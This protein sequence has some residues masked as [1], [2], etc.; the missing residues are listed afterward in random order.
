MESGRRDRWRDEE[1]DTI[2]SIRKDRWREGERE[3]SDNRRV[4]RKVDLS[5]RQSGEARR[6]PGER[7][8]DSGNRDTHDLH[9]ESKW[10][11]RWGPDDKDTDVARDKWGDYNKKDRVL[12]KGSSHLPKDERDGDHYRPWRLNSSYA[13]GRM[14]PGNQTLTPNKQVPAF[15]H[16]RGRG[17]NPAHV[18]SLGRGKVTSGVS[19]VTH[20]ASNLQSLG[21]AV[22]KGESGH[23]ELYPVNYS[24]TKLIDIYRVTDMVSYARY[25]EGSYV[26]VPSL[27]QE[28]SIEPLAFCEPT[29]EEVVI[30]K[31]IDEG[32]I[33]SS[34]APQISKD[35]GS[36][37]RI[38]TDH[39]QT[40]RNRIGTKD[41]FPV[42]LDESKHGL[43]SAEG[44]LNYSEGLSHE[45]RAFSDQKLNSEGLM[46]DYGIHQKESDISTA[47]EL[48]SPGSSSILH[49]GS[50]RS[51][52][53]VERPRPTSDRREVP[54][55]I[56]KDFNNVWDSSMMASPNTKNGGPKWQVGDDPVIRRQPPLMFDREPE[57]HKISQPSPEDL[58]LYYKDPQGEI[59]GPF[60]GSDIISWFES[61]YFGLELQVRLGG[62]PPSSPFSL[63]GDVMPHL[64]AKARPPPGFSMTKINE[65][66]DI[67]N[68]LNYSGLGGL[69]TFLG[70]ADVTKNDQ[71]YTQGSATE[72]ENRFLES[73]M[74][75][76]MSGGSLEKF[77]LSEAMQSQCG[78]NTFAQQPP[79]VCNSGDERYAL[80]KMLALERQRSLPNPYTLWPGRD[81]AT[82]DMK[83]TPVAHSKLLQCVTDN[84]STLHHSQNIESMHMF[85]GSSDRPLTA[86]NAASWLNF[87]AG[88]LNPL[89]DKLDIHYHQNFPP[90]SAYGIQQERLPPHT[91]PSANLLNPPLDPSKMLTQENL[92]GSGMSDDPRLLSLL[93]Q[94]YLLQL[95]QQSHTSV[96]S[97]HL[98]IL[99]QM[100]LLK[101]QQKQ[102]EQQ[103]LM[104]QQQQLLSQVL[105]ERE[106][107]QRL[108]EAPFAQLQAGGFM[109]GNA[110]A[111]HI[112]IQQPQELFQIAS[113]SLASNVSVNTPD[114]AL[115]SGV[116]QDISLRIGSDTSMHLPQQNF[117]NN[118]KENN[119][120]ASLLGHVEQ[121]KG[122]SSMDVTDL[123]Q[124][125]EKKIE[126]TSEPIPNINDSARVLNSDIEHLAESISQQ[127]I[128]FSH[129]EEG[130]HRGG[131]ELMETPVGA[132]EEQ[133]A[134]KHQ[135]CDSSPGN[136]AK[137]RETGEIKKAPEKKS[138]K[139]KSTKASTD[140]GKGISKA[141]QL[142]LTE[143]DETTSSSAKSETNLA[144]ENSSVASG[145]KKEKKKGNKVS[146]NGDLLTNQIT[147][148]AV[149][150][151][152]GVMAAET[153]LQTGPDAHAS[154]LNIEAQTG[155]RAWKAAPG[156]KPKSL[157]EIQQEEQ[158]RVQKVTAVSEIPTTLSHTSTSTPWA[159]VVSKA[160]PK[161]LTEIP[162]DASSKEQN[163]A[164]SDSSSTAQ[165]KKSQED[166]FWDSSVSHLHEKEKEIFESAYGVPLTSNMSSQTDSF[167]D[168]DFI[169]AKEIRKSYKKS[170][171]KNAGAKVA[172]VAP[173]D[174][175]IGSSPVDKGKSTRQTQ[176]QKD[177]LPAVPSGPSLGDFVL[178]K[179]EQPASP[180]APAWS[181]DSGKPQKPMSL[182]E[183]LKE[184]E[185]REIPN[186]P[187]QKPATT[188]PARVNAPSWSSSPAKAA[189]PVPINS[190][191]ASYTKQ[192]VDDDL[193]WGPLEQSRA[194]ENLSEF[195]QLGNQ[196]SWGSKSTPVKG[197]LGGSLNRQKS[198][199]GKSSNYLPSNPSSQAHSSVKGKKVDSTK[200]S[201]AMDFREWCES[202]SIRLLGSKDT[203]ILEYCLKIPKSE[204][205]TLLVENL[206]SL[207]ANREFIDKFLN[208]RDFLPADILEIAFKNPSDR[209]PTVSA[210]GDNNANEQG[211][212]GAIDGATKGGKKKG[213]K[214]KKVS[215]SVLGFNVV[216]NRIMMGEIH[217]VD[218]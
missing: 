105:S 38:T 23:G 19:S 148:P 26:Q 88:G 157:L 39:L 215:P 158:R 162:Q 130:S 115:A 127:H 180:P 54:A 165:I 112:H 161:T 63:L 110:N 108:G 117:V 176:Q 114:F 106:Q 184:Q 4:D 79:L 175:S 11:T 32:E 73:L 12:D 113:Q 13:R 86:N 104:R 192:K 58:V 183:I 107:I 169:D 69:N 56:Q 179:G 126:H 172:T 186:P 119:W 188:Q 48:R 78:N 74:T 91:T 205:E 6:V 201:E 29:A 44:L 92:L 149:D 202:E 17:E 85:P 135:I 138:K 189:T 99:D 96:A 123:F 163:V 40:R 30:L 164:K 103:Q 111:D 51:S 214:G 160:D 190:Q 208:Y 14:D 64:R 144:Q 31:G 198:T 9:R 134:Q 7:W 218:E 116:A 216:S 43:D 151:S 68:R 178:W 84:S 80:A 49:G 1:R 59:Q 181:T 147:L 200:N 81:V 5:G 168:G 166:S 146:D 153:K 25:L 120:D 36:A 53:F 67:S 212:L 18:F 194:E 136:I 90:Q 3:H 213:K 217:T 37:G 206:G 167:N 109:A 42:T 95:Q 204:A 61:G 89:Q 177:L 62:A 118:V 124:M 140:A 27:T 173:V 197:T 182:R 170:K 83:D 28:E 41:D 152:D 82:A 133:D 141:Q 34:G 52:S 16:G 207:D 101:Q 191:A 196:G 137:I 210:A 122:S 174:V 142:K 57:P 97:Q 55:D 132:V 94:Q 195:P 77:A 70:D 102:E 47:K 211:T 131:N 8:N 72:A 100:L 20:M 45:K 125:P 209:K 199:G 171:A 155:Q 46:E 121:H 35:G 50:W 87:P 66:Q 76:K 193:F 203:S 154:P 2:S 75:G 129:A 21:S 159:G 93:Q 33:I 10:N 187:I 60:S 185:K 22:E 15:L 143:V 150:H 65:P 128:E 71:R 139:Q 24:R 156:F 98:P 145:T